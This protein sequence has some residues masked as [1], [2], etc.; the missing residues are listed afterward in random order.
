MNKSASLSLARS[1]LV[2]LYQLELKG[3]IGAAPAKVKHAFFCLV[4]PRH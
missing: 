4:G 2:K 3:I 1:H